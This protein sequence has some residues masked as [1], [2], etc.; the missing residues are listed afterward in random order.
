MTAPGLPISRIVDVS[1]VLSPAAA[2]FPNFDS[3][4]ILGTSTQIDTVTRLREFSSA[5]EV[6]A[7][8]GS[9]AEETLAAN[10]WFSQV[11]KP[12]SLLIGRWAQAAS[13]GQLIGGPVSA[14]NQLLSAWTGITT[15]AMELKIDGIPYSINGMNFSACVNMNGVAAVI[16]TALQGALANTLCVWDAIDSRFII[17]SPTTGVTSSVSLVSLPRATG[18]ILFGGQPANNDTVTINGT[19]VT[20]KTAGPVGPQVLIGASLSATIV[21]LTNFLNASADANI[22]QGIYTSSPT[23]LYVEAKTAGAPG[24]TFTLAAS[25]ATPSGATLSG[26]SGADISV[27]ANIHAAPAY[28]ANGVAPETALQAVIILDDMYSSAWYGLVIPS[29]S[30]SDTLAV[31]A[32]IEADSVLHFFGVTTM[33]ASSLLSTSTTDIIYLLHQLGLKRTM[34]QYSSSSAYAVVSALA[35]ILTT[36]WDGTQTAITL[37]FKT[38][39]G[40]AAESLTL[41]QVNALEAKNGNV[42]VKY[43]NDVAILEQGITPSGQFVDAIIGSDWFATFIQSGVFNALY[44]NPTKI[45]QTDAGNHVLSTVIENCCN[46][47]VQNGLVAPGVW[48]AP[49][50]G[51]LKQGDTLSK[52]FY[53]YTP[54]VS[55]QSQEDRDARKSVLFQV[56][57]KYAGAIHSADVVINV[58]Q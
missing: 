16:Q 14:A 7:F 9:N 48:N 39:P 12:T 57:A 44:T 6:A 34:A 18:N 56:A 35:R 21:N 5:L 29:A 25:V 10:E 45:P 55:S 20:F 15:G 32:Y 46:Q 3:C 37:K 31:S 19:V 42:F 52:G 2:Q 47:A 22:V 11:P 27:Q 30:D 38:E 53:V 49:G 54:P 58:N 26:G 51:Q 50:F 41:T 13:S 24:N 33:D 8:F 28:P 17:T 40:V 4:L 43:T 23:R 1:I 36:N